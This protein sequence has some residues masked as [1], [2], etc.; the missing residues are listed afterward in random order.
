MRL[1]HLALSHTVSSR[2]SSSSPAVKLLK[3]P[4]GRSRLSHGGRRRLGSNTPAVGA[5][6]AVASPEPSGVAI[7]GNSK[8]IVGFWPSLCVWYLRGRCMSTP[9]RARRPGSE[10]IL[11]AAICAKIL[12]IDGPSCYEHSAP[13][14]SFLL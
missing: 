8:P 3:L 2:S 12:L 13:A 7:T 14:L 9:R 11:P 10:P 6:Q 4:L 5:P 1:G